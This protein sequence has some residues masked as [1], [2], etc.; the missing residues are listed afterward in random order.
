MIARAALAAALAAAIAGCGHL[1]MPGLAAT[2]APEVTDG[3]YT[4]VQ[5][6]QASY[7]PISKLIDEIGRAHV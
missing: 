1:P 4:L 3:P 5:E 2:T 6:P 7:A